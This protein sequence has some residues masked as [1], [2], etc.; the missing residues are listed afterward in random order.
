MRSPL[1]FSCYVFLIQLEVW[2]HTA[3]GYIPLLII[4]FTYESFKY[5]SNYKVTSK[6]ERKNF[7]MSAKFSGL[8][9]LTALAL[10]L[11][12]G[13]YPFYPPKH[14]QPQDK[15]IPSMFVRHANF[16]QIEKKLN[17]VEINNTQIIKDVFQAKTSWDNLDKYEVGACV[18]QGI[19]NERDYNNIYSFI[20]QNFLSNPEN[21]KNFPLVIR[22]YS[23]FS[24]KI[25]SS[26]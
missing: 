15:D 16:S 26:I 8:A 25:E 17:P 20:N 23:S 19:T 3:R 6:M 7:L 5:R 10:T 4:L 14:L 18:S 21:M 12:S 22:R 1:A 2:F 11:N 24:N 9:G 13:C